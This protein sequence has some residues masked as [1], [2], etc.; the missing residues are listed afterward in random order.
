MAAFH[1]APMRDC[2]ACSY[3]PVEV[4]LL[5]LGRGRLLLAIYL[6][7]RGPE[8]V[9]CPQA[10]TLCATQRRWIMSSC[11][12][13]QEPLYFELEKAAQQIAEVGECAVALSVTGDQPAGVYL[14]FGSAQLQQ[15]FLRRVRG[16]PHDSS[17][18]TAC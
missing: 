4:R 8:F 2:S 7:V 11:F 18:L 13:T 9:P 15:V 14:S 10:I 16:E 1:L 5:E 17:E 6:P 12:A 3:V